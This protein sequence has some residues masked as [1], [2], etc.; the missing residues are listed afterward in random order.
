MTLSRLPS[1]FSPCANG[2]GGELVLIQGTLHIQQH[3]TINDNRASIKSHFQPQGAGGTEL[4]TGDTYNATGR[5]PGTRLAPAPA[6][7]RCSRI[8]VLNNFKLIGQG[9][10]NNLLV[11]QTIH[12]TV[13]ADGV[14]TS[15]LDNTSVECR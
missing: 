4:T 15:V 9:R 13:N 10:E 8:Y 3:I 2:G 7:R 12:T 11:H 1:E 6:H 5:D 14:V